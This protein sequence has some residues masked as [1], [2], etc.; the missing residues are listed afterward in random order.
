MLVFSHSNVSLS[1]MMHDL[2]SK[3][4]DELTRRRTLYFRSSGDGN[5]EGFF[6]MIGSVINR[7]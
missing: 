3:K 4:N 2:L 1:D 5:T 7:T 6:V